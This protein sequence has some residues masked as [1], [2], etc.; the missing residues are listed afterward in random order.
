MNPGNLKSPLQR[1]ATRLQNKFNVG[2]RRFDGEEGFKTNS[3]QGFLLYPPIFGAYTELFAGLSPD[4][5]SMASGCYI[6]PRGRVG[7]LKEN[8]AASLKPEAEGG[9]GVAKRFYEWCENETR[10][11]MP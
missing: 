1:Y 3:M 4:I 7:Y 9:T 11:Y 5:T 10:Q 6:I 2:L 8:L